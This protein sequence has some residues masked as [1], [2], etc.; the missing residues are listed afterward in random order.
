MAI[1]YD[2]SNIYQ[3]NGAVSATVT[4]SS[5]TIA[6][7]GVIAVWAM[8]CGDATTVSSVTW[9]PGGTGTEALTQ[10]L[11]TTDDSGGVAASNSFWLLNNPTSGAGTVQVVYSATGSAYQAF[12]A[13][14]YTGVENSSVGA[15]HRG[16]QHGN[17]LATITV[18]T[19]AGDQVIS[20]ISYFKVST[21]PSVGSGFTLRNSVTQVGT[22]AY[23]VAVEDKVASGSSTTTPW[24]TDSFGTSTIVSDA[25]IPASGGAT[26]P[27]SVIQSSEQVFPPSAYQLYKRRIFSGFTRLK[28][29]L[30]FTPSYGSI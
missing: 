2:N 23:F 6:S 3:N 11:A 5:W 18:T 20:G 7:G 19:V 27:L 30:I 10:I 28:G 26:V 1:A 29:K 16:V 15:M 21:N 9:K 13:A 17:D 14:S 25:L 8:Y 12:V 22:G 24:T 4:G